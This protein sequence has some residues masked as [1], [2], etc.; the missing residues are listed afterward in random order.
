MP[1]ITLEEIE[2]QLFAAKSWKAPGEDG[3]PAIV[4]KMTWPTV[5]HRVLDLFQ[6]SLEEGTLPRQWRPAKIM[7]LRKPNK[8]NYTVAK[9]WT[10][11]SLLAT[12][13]KILES[14]VAERISHAVETHGLLPTSHFGAQKQRSAEQALVLLQEQIFTAWRGRR[15]L[16]LI[17]FDVKGAYNGVCKNRL[18]QRMKARGIQEDLLRWVEA[19]CSERTAT[20]Q[21]N[22][23]LSEA[24]S[25]PQAGLPQGSPLSPILFLFFNA[26][27]VQRQI[28]SQGGA[29]AF[30]DDFTAWVTGPTAQSNQQGIEAIINEALEWE[31][32]SEREEVA[33]RSRQ[34]K[35]LSYT[36]L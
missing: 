32:R 33:R 27:L 7:P 1:A 24:Q 14:V 8:E 36:S 9:A 28:D 11:I 10:P 25:L 20:I 4:W 18:L 21:I 6:A 16:S 34:K 26:D 17:S 2:R 3:L 5:K 29:I 12:L 23:Q 31:R 15:V 30:V 35:Q 13:G 22:G 19:F